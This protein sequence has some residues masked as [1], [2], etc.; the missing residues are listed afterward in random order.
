MT[1]SSSVNRSR[2]SSGSDFLQLS[3][4][5]SESGYRCEEPHS[6]SALKAAKIKPLTSQIKDFPATVPGIVDAYQNFKVTAQYFLKNEGFG[7]YFIPENIPNSGSD[8]D[9]ARQKAH[10]NVMIS[11]HK[12]NNTADMYI[13]DGGDAK[14]LAVALF[15][16]PQ[17]Q[18]QFLEASKK[19]D[20]FV[21]EISE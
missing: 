18:A 7:F 11:L 15:D 3:D 17:R 13:K 6:F 21:I 5:G 9:W 12:V 16:S 14:A 10:N 8:F 20:N 1:T 2:T 19:G 4:S